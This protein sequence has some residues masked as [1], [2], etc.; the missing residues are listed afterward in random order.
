[1]R[2]CIDPGHGGT[3]PGCQYPGLSERAYVLELAKALALALTQ[4]GH[5]ATLT[6]SLDTTRSFTYRAGVAK[7]FKADIAISLHVNADTDPKSHGLQTYYMPDDELAR[8]LAVALEA[9]APPNLRRKKGTVIA[10]SLDGLGDDAVL[11]RY[12][13]PAALVELAFASNPD[14]RAYLLSYTGQQ[15]IVNALVAGIERYAADLPAA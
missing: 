2:V 13:M 6:R 4:H 14:D 12:E 9:C 7:S 10:A 11:H 15:A 8:R 3:N 5:Q 1:M